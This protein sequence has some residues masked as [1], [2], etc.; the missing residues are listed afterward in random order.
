MSEGFTDEEFP[1]A[2]RKEKALAYL[3]KHGFLKLPCSGCKMT[4]TCSGHCLFV[5]TF[6][7]FS[8]EGCLCAS[9]DSVIRDKPWFHACKKNDS[10]VQI[11]RLLTLKKPEEEKE[12]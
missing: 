1:S 10:L 3:K 5:S 4:F 7:L 6:G 9:C 8:S 2:R 11:L 12:I